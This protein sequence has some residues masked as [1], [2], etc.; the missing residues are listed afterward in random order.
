MTQL[1][2]LLTQ[3]AE[4]IILLPSGAETN[5]WEYW[6]WPCHLHP[7]RNAPETFSTS[8]RPLEISPSS[9][10]IFRNPCATRY[11]DK[12]RSPASVDSGNHQS[13]GID[14][15]LSELHESFRNAS[16][17]QKRSVQAAHLHSLA[18]SLQ[19]P[20]HVP[21]H[22]SYHSWTSATHL[23]AKAGSQPQTW[24]HRV[25]VWRHWRRNEA[26]TPLMPCLRPSL[27]SVS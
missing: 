22:V 10:A 7:I 20:G 27:A 15:D 2:C 18:C 23:A 21:T 3:L 25:S 9:L 5:L 1:I 8:P 13:L 12:Q 4:H 14:E 19:I 11:S 24:R 6:P 16:P 17:C 26:Y